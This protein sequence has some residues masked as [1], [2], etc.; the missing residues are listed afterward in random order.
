[1]SVGM[2]KTADEP[3]VIVIDDDEHVRTAVSDLLRSVR[4]KVNSFASVPDF[5]KWKMPD[6]P[7]CL[8]LDVRL[9]G[10]SG[11]DLQS[12]LNKSGVEV[13]IVFMTAHADVPMSVRAMKGGAIDFLPKPFRDQDLLDAVQQGL[14]ADRKRRATTNVREQLVIAYETL[15]PREKE[16]MALIAAGQMNKQIA[17]RL[18]VSVVTVKFHRGNIMRKLHARTIAELVRMA[19][20][21]A[22]DRVR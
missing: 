19:D 9:P 6:A 18:G 5:L 22:T 21:L 17:G 13:P 15:T 14:E 8:V 2:T 4:L 16:I 12:E 1:M 20:A 3:I 10:L 7:S 11:L